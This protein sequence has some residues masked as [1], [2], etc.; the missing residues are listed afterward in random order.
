MGNDSMDI[1]ALNATL[2]DLTKVVAALNHTLVDIGRLMQAETPPQHEHLVECGVG[3]WK[4]KCSERLIWTDQNREI[5]PNYLES[6]GW[7]FDLSQHGYW[8][9]DRHPKPRDPVIPHITKEDT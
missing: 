6:K 1:R 3:V 5:D 7:W 4:N 8:V 2:K 9:C